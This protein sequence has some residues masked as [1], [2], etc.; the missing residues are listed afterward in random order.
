[1]NEIN[2]LTQI[3][4]AGKR[5]TLFIRWSRGPELD[6]RQGRSLDYSNHTSHNGLSAQP[7]RAD[8]PKLLAQMLV[9][10]AY[11]CRK[12]HKIY[13]WIFS[14]ERNGTDSDNAPT[15]ESQTIVPL[16]KVSAE[17]IKKCEAYAQAENDH[18][19]AYAY[20]AWRPETISRNNELSK[21]VIQ[22]W[23]AIE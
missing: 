9:E 6:K 21:A 15:V 7:V 10:Y 11:L 2:S 5:Q 8:N 19:K 20:N 14:A 4:E 3:I 23:S 18:R 12:D 16:G 17:L 1:M 22:A 13:C